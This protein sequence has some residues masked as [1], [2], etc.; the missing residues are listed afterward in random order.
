[1]YDKIINLRFEIKYIVFV[2][3][4]S[5]LILYGYLSKGVYAKRI[6]GYLYVVYLEIF[7]GYSFFNYPICIDNY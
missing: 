5:I 2:K 4:A 1:M 7:L 6:N 3:N